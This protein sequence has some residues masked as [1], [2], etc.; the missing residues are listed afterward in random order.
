MEILQSFLTLSAP[1]QAALVTGSVT[2]LNVL[3]SYLYLKKSHNINTKNL[4]INA[5]NS[6]ITEEK[7]YS[8]VEQLI[9][10]N[11]QTIINHQFK[12]I[13][14]LSTRRS[15]ISLAKSKI[16]EL[17]DLYDNSH[18]PYQ[19]RELF[20]SPENTNFIDD[21]KE[22]SF[23]LINE[24][25]RLIIQSISNPQEIQWVIETCSTRKHFSSY[26]EIGVHENNTKNGIHPELSR[27]IGQYIKMMHHPMHAIQNFLD[28]VLKSYSTNFGKYQSVDLNFLF[29][30]YPIVLDFY[31]SDLDNEECL[32]IKIK[33]NYSY[34]R[35]LYQEKYHKE[36]TDLLNK[37]GSCYPKKPDE[38]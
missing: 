13:Q 30:K 19:K 32:K 16:R 18:A 11:N 10:N 20:S 14:E 25:E 3:I 33:E 34:L 26:F 35:E 2:A 37:M 24:I 8:D 1:L 31:Y 15:N 5:K 17:N 12:I 28:D 21:L 36:R 38:Q 6:K 4:Q 29:G 27:L 9:N 22:K 23:T 7:F